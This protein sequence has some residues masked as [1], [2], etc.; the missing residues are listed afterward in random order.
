MPDPSYRDVFLLVREIYDGTLRACRDA[1]DRVS[2]ETRRPWSQAD[3]HRWTPLQSDAWRDNHVLFTLLTSL[4]W[5][6]AEPMGT[7]IVMVQR[8]FSRGYVFEPNLLVAVTP[9]KVRRI[10]R[11]GYALEMALR[12]RKGTVTPLGGADTRLAEVRFEGGKSHARFHAFAV[13]L[14]RLVDADAL[15][16]RVT[17]PLLALL[18][19]DAEKARSFLDPGDP[20]KVEFVASRQGDEPEQVG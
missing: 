16:Q 4:S 11:S 14:D 2:Q 12:D 8:Y 1:M 7:E 15:H 18:D 13:S 17:C 3:Q 5:R 6:D 19:G 9:E 20:A 10:E